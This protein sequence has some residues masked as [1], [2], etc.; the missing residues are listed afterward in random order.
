MIKLDE[1][2]GI[3]AHMKKSQHKID[4]EN[5]DVM[6]SE[7]R[8]WRRR[9]KQVLRIRAHENSTRNLDCDLTVD[10]QQL[11][12]LSITILL[13]LSKCQYISNFVLS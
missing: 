1:K 8:Y 7:P 13:V 6:G 9:V 10:E 11:A 2:N 3:A 12:G 5:A 4:W